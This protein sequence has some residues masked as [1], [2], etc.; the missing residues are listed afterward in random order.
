MTLFFRLTYTLLL[1]VTLSCPLTGCGGGGGESD[2]AAAARSSRA[3]ALATLPAVDAPRPGAATISNFEAGQVH[4]LEITPDGKRLL[5]VNTANGTLEIFDVSGATVALTGVVKV[6]IDPVSVRAASNTEAWVVNVS[7]DSVSVVDLVN[8]VVKTTLATDDEPAD[9]VFAGNPRRAY[10][11]CAQARNLSVFDAVAP[12]TPLARIPILGQQPRMLATSADGLKVYLA[13]FESGNGTLALSAKISSLEPNV[14]RDPA[15]PYG[16]VN[17]PPNANNATTFNPPLN[18]A[19]PPPPA[20]VSLIVRRNAAGDWLDDNGR[21]WKRWVNGGPSANGSRASNRVAGWDL[22]DRDVAVIDTA[23]QAVTY[24]GGMLNM[25]MALAVNPAS[26]RIT[27]VGTDATNQIRFEPVLSGTFLRVLYG[28][29]VPGQSNSVKDLNAHLS[30]SAPRT[31]VAER[32]KSLGDPR[33]IVWNAAGTKAY[34]TGLGSNN[35]IVLDAQGQRAGLQPTIDVGQGPTGVVL[36]ESQRRAFV[37]NRFDATLSVVNLD[38]EAVSATVPLS[39]DA[40][41]QVVR[42]GRPMLYDTHRFSGLGH[43]SCASCHVDGKTDRLAWDLGDPSG[44]M[45]STTGANGVT[46]QHHP[47]KGPLL[48][49]TLVDAMQSAFLHW[50]GDRATL[51]HFS[52]AFRTLQGA[53]A[54]ATPTEIAAMNAFLE[55]LRTPPNPYRN[56]DNS[57]ST[58]VQMPG[59]R[60]S[61]LRVG[62]AVLGAQEFEKGCRSCHLGHTGRGNVFLDR[63]QFSGG[64]IFLNPPRWQNFY[65]RDGLWFG[66]AT[67]STAGFGFQQDG[68]YDSTHNG[69][70]SD[71]L[72]AFMYSFNGSFPYTPIGLSAQTVAVDAHA[73]VGRQVT[74]SA[75]VVADPVLAQLTALADANAIG[76]VAHGCVAG[77][78]RGYAYRGTGLFDADRANETATLAELKAIAVGGSPISF[79]AVRAGTALQS[80]IDRDGDGVRDGAQGL[81]A[82][83]SCTSGSVKS[84]LSSGS[85]EGAPVAAGGTAT[86]TTLGGWRGSNGIKVSRG[87]QGWLAVDGD[88][89]VELDVGRG[90]DVL[91]QP[92]SDKAGE[93]LV[94]RFWYSARPGTS[95]ATNT[96]NVRWNGTVID[97]VSPDGGSLTAPL[98]QSRSY[99]VQAGGNDTLS[100]SEAG[101]DDGA[102]TLIDAVTLVSQGP[103]PLPQNLAFNKPA[104]QSSWGYGGVASRAV[105]GNTNGIYGS[106]SVTHSGYMSQPW[107]QVDLGGLAAIQSVQLWNRT[108]CCAERLANFT[109]FVSA[110]DMAGRTMAQLNT[111]AS[112]AK[113]QVASL[114]GAASVNLPLVA[115]G[116]FVR[117]QLSGTNYLSLAEV[118]VLGR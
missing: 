5:S 12:T 20:G 18:P 72:M 103:A 61:T 73:A 84:L 75:S 33:G 88:A 94:L 28:S 39:Y 65:R 93:T 118:Q 112:V 99:V 27:V 19:N 117:V 14:V 15:G 9:V 101:I 71:N 42:D 53:D 36:Q 83:R 80:G 109:V 115:N 3:Q 44:A 41:P 60:G 31:A 97:T 76:L 40:T 79:T 68:T 59:P 113:V 92:V 50:R 81:T 21:N 95:A 4:P 23:T 17:P 62:N 16:G 110:S 104:T 51:A 105:D 114:N 66:D 1:T 24:Q 116:R 89:W 69:T 57:Y 38:T 56:L 46:V 85:F 63:P 25:V 111:D 30:Y 47:M 10:V 106:G 96:F 26:G 102:G 8:A 34:V 82:V 43:I 91:S 90:L 45:V 74:L 77:E 11:S 67:G 64:G 100:F 6:G 48:T 29:F 54:D 58:S 49:Q 70:R 35:L 52:G 78:R 98:W 13:I 22:I 55:S 7:S 2:G 107:W 86:V 87:A 32:N 37:L 108:D